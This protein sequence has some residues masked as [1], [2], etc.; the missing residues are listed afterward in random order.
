MARKSIPKEIKEQVIKR[1]GGKH[2][3]KCGRTDSLH[4]HHHTLVMYGGMDT[5]DNLTILC[6]ACH[7]EWHGVEDVSSLAFEEWLRWPPCHHL[8]VALQQVEKADD[9]C[10]GQEVV[11][12]LKLT[13]RAMFDQRKNRNYPSPCP[14]P[15]ISPPPP[16]SQHHEP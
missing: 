10:S 12:L 4:F 11:S 5:P 13:G 9:I 7:S 14:I 2:C 15:P 8:I 1:I 16:P 3:V 6:S